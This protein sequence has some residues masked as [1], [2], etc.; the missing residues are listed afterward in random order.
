MKRKGSAKFR[1]AIVPDR[2][3]MTMLLI[4]ASGAFLAMSV[5]LAFDLNVDH[6]RVPSNMRLIRLKEGD[7]V[8]L[9]WTSDQPLVVNLHGY[10]IDKRALRTLNPSS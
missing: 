9:R 10:D 4:A 1:V 7:V 8:K 6:D 5:E 2:F 3:I